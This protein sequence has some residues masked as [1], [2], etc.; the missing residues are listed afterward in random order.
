MKAYAIRHIEDPADV[1]K[2]VIPQTE[3]AKAAWLCSQAIYYKEDE[4][5]QEYVK[6]RLKMYVFISITFPTK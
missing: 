6:D 1:I 5:D 3:E 2:A 4:E